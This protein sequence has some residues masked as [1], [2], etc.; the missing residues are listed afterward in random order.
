MAV[1]H[2]CS[3]V[4]AVDQA[5]CPG[6]DENNE[7]SLTDEISFNH[8][9]NRVAYTFPFSLGSVPKE[10]LYMALHVVFATAKAGKVSSGVCGVNNFRACRAGA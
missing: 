9:G 10:R 7:S 8:H 3:P 4:S 5:P 2:V 1:W 6:I